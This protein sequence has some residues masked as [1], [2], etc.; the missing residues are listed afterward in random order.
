MAELNA[1][2]NLTNP[3]VFPV[4]NDE[5]RPFPDIDSAYLA[6]S[7]VAG[8]NDM[9]FIIIQ[10]EN[11]I[12]KLGL[13]LY[14]NL[15]INEDVSKSNVIII[16]EPIN[17]EED[18]IS[19]TN[20]NLYIDI[21][22]ELQPLKDVNIF[23]FNSIIELNDNCDIGSDINNL[24]IY[25]KVPLPLGEYYRPRVVCQVNDGSTSFIESP[26]TVLLNRPAYSFNVFGYINLEHP[27]L[28]KTVQTPFINVTKEETNNAEVVLVSISGDNEQ[29]VNTYE[30]MPDAALLQYQAMIKPNQLPEP[31]NWLIAITGKV[32]GVSAIIGGGG[33][34]ALLTTA[35]IT[36]LMAGSIA[37]PPL[38]IAT[39]I[40]TGI[41]L[42]GGITLVSI[43]PGSSINTAAAIIDNITNRDLSL[44]NIDG[45]N[46]RYI[47]NEKVNS[48]FY[49]VNSEANITNSS[50][51]NGRIDS[52]NFV[53]DRNKLYYDFNNNRGTKHHT[54]S[55]YHMPT[56]ITTDYIHTEF[57]GTIFLVDASNKN[58]LNII[59]PI[60]TTERYITY[61]RIDTSEA[62]VYINYEG[63]IDGYGSTYK[64]DKNVCGHKG[65]KK[66]YSVLNLYVYNG[67]A[68]IL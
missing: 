46:Y 26:W 25:E 23:N 68:Y 17:Q 18:A 57:D 13:K 43:N 27:T 21:K 29:N 35:V 50:I 15:E 20:V 36:S 7:A 10:S 11:G 2:V 65:T 6:L 67:K 47:L 62:V 24:D 38:F 31:P 19:F 16:D 44:I 55:L 56:I 12:L 33:V 53:G 30:I 3:V 61:K 4:I 59:I 37:F 40:A 9:K 32:V 45:L 54:G 60:N 41:T 63:G 64:L 42:A 48:E 51:I 58:E 39:A 1:Y 14:K 22:I 66:L 8:P 34:G 28:Y 5:N 52:P 49:L